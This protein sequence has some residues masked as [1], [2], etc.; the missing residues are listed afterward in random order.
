MVTPT[1]I[2]DWLSDCSVVAKENNDAIEFD[3]FPRKMFNLV[4]SDYGDGEDEQKQG[5]GGFGRI[6]KGTFRQNRATNFL[7]KVFSNSKS[8]ALPMSKTFSCRNLALQCG[9]SVSM[10]PQDSPTTGTQKP[11]R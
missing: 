7:L 5:E 6:C 2:A 10:I 3:V 4:S 8:H 11:M 9:L 1:Y